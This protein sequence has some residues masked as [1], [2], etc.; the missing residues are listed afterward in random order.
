MAEHC[1]AGK[2]PAEI[3]LYDPYFCNG[4]VRKHLASLGLT[5]LVHEDRDFY[6]DVAAAAVPAYDVL[7][8]SPPFSGDHKE[9]ILTFCA[10]S[11][12]PW[13]LLLPRY[14]I[15]RRYFAHALFA[16]RHPPFFVA[17]AG[18][19][20]CY[21]HPASGTKAIKSGVVWIVHAGD[22][23]RDVANACASPAAARGARVV[24]EALGLVD[25]LGR[26]FQRRA[27]RKAAHMLRR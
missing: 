9:R 11:G 25:G 5:K 22:K 14:V 20:Y 7:L 27:A 6:A 10:T 3:G 13:L 17:P 26:N 19:E 12:K 24:P 15:T 2:P 4:A 23:T 8:T 21:S 1:F 18:A 16:L